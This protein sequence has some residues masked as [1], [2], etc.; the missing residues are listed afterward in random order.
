MTAI[1]GEDTASRQL[2]MF[3]KLQPTRLVCL[4]ILLTL[5]SDTWT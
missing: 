2:I 1:W 5:L 4:M 3:R